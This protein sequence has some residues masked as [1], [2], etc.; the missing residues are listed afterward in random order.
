VTNV[1]SIEIDARDGT[2]TL[3]VRVFGLPLRIHPE[4]MT[5]ETLG[6]LL[7]HWRCAYSGCVNRKLHHTDR[8][9]FVRRPH[10]VRVPL[11]EFGA[12]GSRKWHPDSE[13]GVDY[14]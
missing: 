4:P 11:W 3:L 13:M 5:V 2:P 14:R 8:E 7:A 9:C 10:G 12:D 6:R 1:E